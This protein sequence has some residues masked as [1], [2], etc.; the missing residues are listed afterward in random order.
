[1]LLG[2]R[3]HVTYFLISD[4]FNRILRVYFPIWFVLNIFD[5]DLYVLVVGPYV[6]VLTI[7]RAV[8]PVAQSV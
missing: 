4:Y 7:D 2:C 1:M 3:W 6:L 8:G 5:W